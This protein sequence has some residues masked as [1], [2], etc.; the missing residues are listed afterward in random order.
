[1]SGEEVCA[2]ADEYAAEVGVERDPVGK[3]LR[4]LTGVTVLLDES[5]DIFVV[6]CA[7]EC[8]P[9]LNA[10]WSRA[11]CRRVELEKP[12]HC[13]RNWV[14]LWARGRGTLAQRLVAGYTQLEV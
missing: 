12:L 5:V 11:I 7:I 6:A 4:R 3:Y 9:K 2:S 1:M 8:G 10:T 14:Q 13:P